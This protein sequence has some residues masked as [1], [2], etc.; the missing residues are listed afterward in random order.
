MRVTSSAVR[1]GSLL[2]AL[3][4]AACSALPEPETA[5]S[6]TSQHFATVDEA[7]SALVAP[8]GQTSAPHVRL[9][10]PGTYGGG[11]PYVDASFRVTADAYVMVVAIDL[12]RR[13]RVLYPE[14]P[15]ESG[16]MSAS[17]PKRLDRFF[18]GFGNA[19]RG[20]FSFASNAVQPISQYSGPGIVLALA[21]DRPFQFDRVADSDGDWDE[22]ALGRLVFESSVYGAERR[23]GEAL[24]ITGQEFNTDFANF[25]SRGAFGGF[26][27]FALGSY[28][29]LGC[30][31]SF[32]DDYGYTNGYGD[33]YGSSLGYGGFSAGL[34]RYQVV[35]GT[36]YVSYLIEGG[37]GRNYY[38]A[39][40][41]IG[42]EPTRPVRPDTARKPDSV[43]A[44]R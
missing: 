10:I 28:G 4:L 34:V 41:P 12:D 24:A 1:V 39:W 30:G 43:S 11:T 5:P 27:T 37:C 42:M 2:C 40:V 14:A 29:G 3:S 33:A 8:E 38:S 20:R 22:R 31:G 19:N 18:S 35:N 15:N 13:I 16:F 44:S 25:G 6:E 9:F 32:A 17:S 7:R 21:S 36:R 23:L 26:N